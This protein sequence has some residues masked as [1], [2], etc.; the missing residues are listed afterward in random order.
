MRA[1]L[2]A[3]FIGLS[4]CATVLWFETKPVRR[5]HCWMVADGAVYCYA[6]DGHIFRPRFDQFVMEVPAP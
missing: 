2:L 3:S 6:Q 5:Y 1:V 4:I